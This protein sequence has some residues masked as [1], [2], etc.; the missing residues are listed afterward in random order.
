MAVRFMVWLMLLLGSVWMH[1][2]A[3]MAVE[4]EQAALWR[5][6]IEAMKAAPRGPFTRIRWFCND[7]TVLPPGDSA[8]CKHGCTVGSGS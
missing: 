1:A 4:A 6:W 3:V 7:G 2:S 8:C 5:S